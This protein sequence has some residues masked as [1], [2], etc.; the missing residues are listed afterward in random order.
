MKDIRDSLCT[1]S[2]SYGDYSFPFDRNV[3]TIADFD[4]SN[5]SW[6]QIYEEFLVIGHMVGTAAVN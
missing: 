2:A 6:P 5:V 4:F 3:I 1:F